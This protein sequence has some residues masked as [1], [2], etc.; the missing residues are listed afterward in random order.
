MNL[1][2]V[3]LTGRLTRDPESFADGKVAKLGLAVDGREKNGD[4]W[5]DR[6]DFFDV[7]CFGKT[8][9]NVMQYLSKGSAVAVAGRL[10]QD[11][12]KTDSGDNRSK[13]VVIAQVVQF[14]D[15]KKD[16]DSSNGN[17]D[18]GSSGGSAPADDDIPFARPRIADREVRRRDLFVGDRSWS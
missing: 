18:S 17:T 15:P 5:E 2:T 13:V 11:R 12:W 3:T 6:P 4:T 14:L 7:T 16:D 1:N 9:E 8:A 10:R